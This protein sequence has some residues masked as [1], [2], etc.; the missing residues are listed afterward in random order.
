M[1]ADLLPVELFTI[2]AAGFVL[3]GLL[4]FWIHPKPHANLEIDDAP[5]GATF[6]DL[7]K[8]VTYLLT[9]RALLTVFCM[10]LTVYIGSGAQVLLAIF[11][12]DVFELGREGVGLLYAF[13]GIGMLIGPVAI[14]LLTLRPSV[15][16][17][18]V[19]S[20]ALG[21]VGVGYLGAVLLTDFGIWSVGAIFALG[22]AGAGVVRML[23]MSNLQEQCAPEHLPQILALEQGTSSVVQSAA[24]VLIGASV[25]SLDAGGAMTMSA[26]VG[27]FLLA[28][29]LAWFQVSRSSARVTARSA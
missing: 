9:N 7:M 29:A 15:R 17:G 13:R 8:A 26:A 16:C 24:A 12:N 14:M 27:V 20:Y 25:G 4:V 23:T 3:S 2:I 6:Q 10:R 22:F 5:P 19:V 18:T 28:S 1:G 21:L 11:A